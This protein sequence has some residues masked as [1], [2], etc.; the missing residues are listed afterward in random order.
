MMS[1]DVTTCDD[2][3]LQRIL[4]HLFLLDV[5]NVHAFSGQLQKIKNNCEHVP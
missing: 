5:A 3:L 2:K 1:L 4:Q